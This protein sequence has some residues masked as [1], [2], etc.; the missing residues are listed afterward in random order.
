MILN[1]TD[2][3]GEKA[4]FYVSLLKF[5]KKRRKNK[6]Y[7]ETKPGWEGNNEHKLWKRAA[8]GLTRPLSRWSQQI[9]LKTIQ[10]AVFWLNTLQEKENDMMLKW[11]DVY[12]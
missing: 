8:S 7:T 12:L 10:I 2:I 6:S 5:T 4:K 3:Q 11:Y 1:I 9:V